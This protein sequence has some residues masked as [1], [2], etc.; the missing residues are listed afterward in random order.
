YLSV[1][2]FYP[3]IQGRFLRRTKC[4]NDAKRLKDL[5]MLTININGLTLCH[6]G[7]NCISHNTLPDVCGR[8][9]QRTVL[10]AQRGPEDG[11]YS[12]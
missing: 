6:K 1:A 10:H 2:W 9:P 4:G 12:A 11:H 7:S 3:H 5:D 8:G